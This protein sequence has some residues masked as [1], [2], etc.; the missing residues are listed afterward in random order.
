MHWGTQP[1]SGFIARRF[2]NLCA[3]TFA[4]RAADPLKAQG[5]APNDSNR[6]LASA[7]GGPAFLVSSSPRTFTGHSVT[8]LLRFCLFEADPSCAFG[9][10]LLQ[11]PACF[12]IESFK[13]WV[14]LSL[15]GIIMRRFPICVPPPMRREPLVGKPSYQPLNRRRPIHS[16]SISTSF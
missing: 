7:A 6:T 8:G 3:A 11:G 9:A 15:S 14:I 12:G 13:H 5:P 1:P 4:A 10:A 2:P 16:I